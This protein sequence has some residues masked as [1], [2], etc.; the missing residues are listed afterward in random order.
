MWNKCKEN[1]L[2]LGKPATGQIMEEY[3]EVTVKEVLKVLK[4]KVELRM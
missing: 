2:G 4:L 1:K 3:R